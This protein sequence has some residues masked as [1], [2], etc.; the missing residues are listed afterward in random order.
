MLDEGSQTLTS[1]GCS[2]AS[3]FWPA[4]HHSELFVCSIGPFLQ[5]VDILAHLCVPLPQ[6]DFPVIPVYDCTFALH[7]IVSEAFR[8]LI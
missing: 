4:G 1:T 8:Q 7:L 3:Y 6:V 5:N 2:F